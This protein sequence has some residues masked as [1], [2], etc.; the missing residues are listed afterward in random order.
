[1]KQ[2]NRDPLHNLV[3]AVQAT[4][5]ANRKAEQMMNTQKKEWWYIEKRPDEYSVTINYKLDNVDA[6]KTSIKNKNPKLHAFMS[7]PT[8]V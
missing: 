8:V 6:F 2:D 7:S 5:L 4:L 3:E 1:M